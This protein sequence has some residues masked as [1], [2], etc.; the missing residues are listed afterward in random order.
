MTPQ[1]VP[2]FTGPDDIDFRAQNTVTGEVCKN[3]ITF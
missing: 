2:D 1:P 3:Q